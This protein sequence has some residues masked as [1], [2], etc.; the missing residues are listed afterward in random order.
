MLVAWMPG[1]YLVSD[2]ISLVMILLKIQIGRTIIFQDIYV[3]II[4]MARVEKRKIS[5]ITI[6]NEYMPSPLL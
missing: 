2:I 1:T 3:Y 4:N 5:H 6:V